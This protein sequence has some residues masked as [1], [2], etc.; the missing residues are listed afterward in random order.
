MRLAAAV[1]VPVV[2]LATL[3]LGAAL[4]LTGSVDSIEP[5]PADIASTPEPITVR[6]HQYAHPD[7]HSVWEGTYV[8][9]QGLAYVKLTVDVDSQGG[10]RARY[11]FGPVPSNPV[12]PKTGAFI[13]I[14]SV[15]FHGGGAFTGELDARQWI[16]H[17]E[18]YFMVPLSIASDDG[19]HMT[20][21]IHHDSCSQ[22]QATRIE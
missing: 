8:C 16:V 6:S 9:A 7:H 20:G 18:N 1:P 14:G 21:R 5:V 22:F 2:S 17:P 10:A 3:S 12:V 19:V 4:C 15:Q 11:D 13:L